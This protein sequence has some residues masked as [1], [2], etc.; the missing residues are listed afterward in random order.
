MSKYESIEKYTVKAVPPIDS[1]SPFFEGDT[2][3]W[4]TPPNDGVTIKDA[5]GKTLYATGIEINKNISHRVVFAAL[6]NVKDNIDKLT[7]HSWV[8]QPLTD[9][10]TGEY[11][12][13]SDGNVKN[14]V[15]VTFSWIAGE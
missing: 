11:E 14:Q 9:Y 10:K 3:N 7:S 1:G 15:T 8:S 12:L 4:V 13:D 2:S 5:E 6:D